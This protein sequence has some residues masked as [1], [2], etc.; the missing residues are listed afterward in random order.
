MPHFDFDAALRE[1]RRDDDRPE[2]V[3]FTY[4]GQDFTVLPDP[5]LG[6]VMDLSRAPELTPETEVAA[7]F[8]CMQFIR[9]ML[10]PGDRQRFEQA[11]YTIP[12]SNSAPAIV[13]LT[14]WLA[15]Q[16]AGFPTQPPDSSP[17][18]SS[19]TSPTPSRR[20]GGRSRSSKPRQRP[21][22]PSSIA[23]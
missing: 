15:E 21:E 13:A 2:P 8:A 5:T 23:S 20:T 7:A 16:V 6:D 22:S 18:G 12:A 10:P 17:T 11:H 19:G 4:G 1:A 14:S 3:T 9:R